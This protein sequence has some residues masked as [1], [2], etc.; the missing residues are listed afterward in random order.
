MRHGTGMA[1]A[2]HRHGTGMSGC[3]YASAT[4]LFLL[5]KDLLER[6]LLRHA[7]VRQAAILHVQLLLA[8]ARVVLDAI[9]LRV[10]VGVGG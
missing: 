4:H 9:E 10:A 6:A 2:W 7:L 1:Q 8:G 3:A 5:A